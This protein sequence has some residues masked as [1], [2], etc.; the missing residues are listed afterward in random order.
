[1][2]GNP[3]FTKDRR[4]MLLQAIKE[5]YSE[6]KANGR[7]IGMTT[8]IALETIGKAM[9]T[10]GY[11]VRIEDHSIEDYKKR[12]LIDIIDKV[13]ANLGLVGFQVNRLKHTLTYSLEHISASE[14]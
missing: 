10:P 12:N 7:Y 9:Q 5:G 8:G 13:I 1:M 14:E 2:I 4:E 3:N 6:S 11:S